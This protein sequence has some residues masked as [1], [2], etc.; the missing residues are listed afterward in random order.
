MDTCVGCTHDHGV[1]REPALV[2]GFKGARDGA[3]RVS[4][5]ALVNVEE[6]TQR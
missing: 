1:E 3:R 5:P 4:R 6:H 2:A